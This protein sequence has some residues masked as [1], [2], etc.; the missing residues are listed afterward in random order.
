MLFHGIRMYC[1]ETNTMPGE[2]ASPLPETGEYYRKE[3]RCSKEDS[4]G[5]FLMGDSGKC[6]FFRETI[7]ICLFMAYTIDKLCTC[8]KCLRGTTF[9]KHI[10][11]IRAEIHFGRTSS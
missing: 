4:G 6:V 10:P 3:I 1:G 5:V 7:A 8:G 11:H 9:G 2:N